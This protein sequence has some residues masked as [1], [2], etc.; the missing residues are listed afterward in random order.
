[1]CERMM[2]SW[3]PSHVHPPPPPQR[4]V[5]R[6]VGGRAQGPLKGVPMNLEKCASAA[7]ACSSA[8]RE[9][10]DVVGGGA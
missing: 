9:E 10:G 8:V 4:R 6:C 7:A 2:M 1:M 5:R 3:A